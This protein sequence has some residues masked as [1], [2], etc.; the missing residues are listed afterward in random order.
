MVQ[1][2]IEQAGVAAEHRCWVAR[3]DDAPTHTP[4]LRIALVGSD[5]VSRIALPAQL[6]AHHREAFAER[7]LTPSRRAS[8]EESLRARGRAA[9]DWSRTGVHFDINRRSAR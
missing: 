2:T 1:V 3:C 5:H 9:P 8:I 6:C 4:I 7:F